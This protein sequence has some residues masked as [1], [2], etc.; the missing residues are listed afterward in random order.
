M[1]SKVHAGLGRRTLVRMSCD[2]QAVL[3]RWRAN[4]GLYCGAG[5]LETKIKTNHIYYATTELR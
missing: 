5:P 2:L 1:T 3:E 4:A